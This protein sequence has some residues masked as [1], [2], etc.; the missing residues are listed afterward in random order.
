VLYVAW[1][2]IDPVGEVFFSTS[3]LL[4]GGGGGDPDV[5]PAAALVG[6]TAGEANGSATVAVNLSKPVPL[7]ET[8]SVDFTTVDGTAT[9]GEDYVSMTG[10]LEFEGGESTKAITVN[11]T[12]DS[13]AE[14][15]EAFAIGLSNP[16]G[17]SIAGAVANV[18]IV[19]DDAAV[20]GGYYFDKTQ[21]WSSGYQGWLVLVNPG[22]DT[23]SAPVVGFEL[24]SPISWFGP[25]TRIDDGDGHH[26]V[27][28][29]GPIPAG[30]EVRFDIVV[31]PVASSDPRGPTNVWVNGIPLGAVADSDRDGLSDDWERQHFGDLGADASGDPDGDGQD[32]AAEELS[33]TDPLDFGDRL[34]FGVGVGGPG[35]LELSLATKAGVHYQLQRSTDLTDWVPDGDAFVGDGASATF[36]F[37]KQRRAFFRVVVVPAS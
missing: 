37:S 5:P 8:A 24:D 16:V 1:Q 29:I 6:T 22:P 14:P 12:N 30:G 11:L 28:G 25:G 15:D 31:Q 36:T 32:N 34:H 7:G 21:D 23:W 19:D 4:F 33:R 3:D 26:T 27:T 20:V 35:V 13:E 2:R 18:T 10:T 9:A 17:V